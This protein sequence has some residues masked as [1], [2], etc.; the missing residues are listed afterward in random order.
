MFGMLRSS[1][2]EADCTG[3]CAGMYMRSICNVVR[4]EA[5]FGVLWWSQELTCRRIAL[6]SGMTLTLRTHISLLPPPCEPCAVSVRPL[7]C[8]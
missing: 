1:V 4:D 7:D 5:K 6:H 3:R 2:C 8:V